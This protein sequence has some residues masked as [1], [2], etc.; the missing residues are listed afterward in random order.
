[1][2]KPPRYNRNVAKSLIDSADQRCLL[3]ACPRCQGQNFEVGLS[4]GHGPCPH[5]GRAPG[6]YFVCKNCDAQLGPIVGPTDLPY[7]PDRLQKL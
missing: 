1:M 2:K 6:L 7:D 5:C 4:R 3:L